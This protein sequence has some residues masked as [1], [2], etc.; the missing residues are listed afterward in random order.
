MKYLLLTSVLISLSLFAGLAQ[1]IPSV[2]AVKIWDRAPHNAFP[3]MIRYR[4]EFYIALREGNDHMPDNSGAIRIIK[5]KDG[6]NWQ[7]VGLLEK[8]DMDVREARLSIT[9]DGRIMVLTAVGVYEKGYTTLYPMVS[10]SDSHGENFTA[11]QKVT[12]DLPSSLDWIW[13]LTWHK[14][15]GYGI[16]YQIKPSGWEVH[17][18]ETSDGIHFDHLSQLPIDGN[19]NEATIRFDNKGKMFVLVRREAGDRMGVLAKSDY[20]YVDWTTSKLTKRLGGPN[21]L[22]LN[23]STL[24]IG[25][26][27]YRDTGSKTAIHITDVDGT[28]KRT[29]ELSSGGDTSYPGMVFYKKNLWIAY[30]SS[31]RGK[32]SIYLSKIPMN[33]LKK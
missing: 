13:S 24:V 3:D 18:L 22:F 26:R 31:H 19:P 33:A 9:P 11:L 20:P 28:I 6:K 1:E 29:I 32:T 27:E 15:T 8:R 14:G 2:D 5:S 16:L 30:Y 25:S 21:F 10:F 17:L 23:M 7:P 12:V 4:G